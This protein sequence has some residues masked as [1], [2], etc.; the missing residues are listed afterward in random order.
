MDMS[1]Y[2]DITRNESRLYR[3]FGAPAIADCIRNLGYRLIYSY[4]PGLS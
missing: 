2:V 3:V 4:R 1:S